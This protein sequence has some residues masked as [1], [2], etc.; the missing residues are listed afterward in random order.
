MVKGLTLTLTLIM[1]KGFL[2]LNI[3]VK[4]FYSAVTH[5][6]AKLLGGVVICWRKR[7]AGETPLIE[8]E[9]AG[10]D[11]RGY[12]ILTPTKL[13]HEIP[14]IPGRKFLQVNSRS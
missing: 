4:G 9:R 5:Q 11:V 13:L 6:L 12:G 1:G 14:S 7:R 10:V 2:I 3:L 8:N